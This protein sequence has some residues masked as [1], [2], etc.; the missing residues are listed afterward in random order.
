M[1][2]KLPVF[3][4]DSFYQDVQC[5]L[6]T[7]MLYKRSAILRFLMCS[8]EGCVELSFRFF[9]FLLHGLYGALC[10][11]VTS[12]LVWFRF[13]QCSFV[14]AF[15]DGLFICGCYFYSSSSLRM[16]IRRLYVIIFVRVTVTYCYLM[17]GVP[18][19]AEE[20]LLSSSRRL[21]RLSTTLTARAYIRVVKLTI[22]SYHFI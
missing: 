10:S 9:L 5:L 22:V 1:V 20:L 7:I 19:V 13:V 12:G 4:L 18:V 3:L 17:C 6:I 15:V 16:S 21:H 2:P 11:R 8:G 14:V